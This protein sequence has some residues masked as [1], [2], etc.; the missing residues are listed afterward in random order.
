M[1]SLTESQGQSRLARLSGCAP[2]QGPAGQSEHEHA[3]S[4]QLDR[5]THIATCPCGASWRAPTIVASRRASSR[6]G[7]A[8]RSGRRRPTGEPK[9]VE[10]SSA[11]RT[12]PSRAAGRAA[13]PAQPSRVAPSFLFFLFL[14]LFSPPS[15]RLRLGRLAVARA[16]AGYGGYSHSVSKEVSGSVCRVCV[17]FA[18]A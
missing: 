12:R 14:L 2:G 8:S 3:D 10:S 16:T 9:R 6:H 1:F 15:D 18:R 5:C 7:H 17:V 4:F 11:R 13:W